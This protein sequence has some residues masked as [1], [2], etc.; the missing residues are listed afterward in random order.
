MASFPYLL[1]FFTYTTTVCNRNGL[2]LLCKTVKLVDV[3][4]LSFTEE[5]L[6]QPHQLY[7]AAAVT[8][9]P[10]CRSSKTNWDVR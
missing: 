8:R 7:N 9:H 6:Q 2:M 5:E 10:A 3:Q 1:F 4:V